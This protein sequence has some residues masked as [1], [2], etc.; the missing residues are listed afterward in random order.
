MR[1]GY[2][3]SGSARLEITQFTGVFMAKTITI[4]MA[5]DGQIT[6]STS[7]GGEPYVCE[8]ID[9]CRKY[10]DMMLSEEQG[11]SP[12]EQATEEPEDYGEMWKE[13]AKARQP[14]PGLMA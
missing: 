1:F 3:L 2:Y 14:Q 13:E 11:E 6:V 8:T 5:D 12:E 10:V 9:E 4:E 7:E